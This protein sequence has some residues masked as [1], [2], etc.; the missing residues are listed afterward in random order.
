MAELGDVATYLVKHGVVG[1]KEIEVYVA[2]AEGPD[3]FWLQKK[4]DENII[5]EMQNELYDLFESNESVPDLKPL[6]GQQQLYAARYSDGNW[7]RA[8]L[9]AAIDEST[10][11]V[12]FVDYG[13]SHRIS[14]LDLRPLPSKWQTIPPIAFCCRLQVPDG[15][16]QW[17]PAIVGFFKKN[18]KSDIV[19]QVTFGAQEGDALIVESLVSP[20]GDIVEDLVKMMAVQLTAATLTHTESVIQPVESVGSPKGDVEEL[21]KASAVQLNAVATVPKI[22]PHQQS[23]VELL[24]PTIDTDT[25]D[26]PD[27]VEE[28]K[29][30]AKSLL[31][32]NRALLKRHNMNQSLITEL[33][34]LNLKLMRDIQEINARD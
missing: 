25:E 2:F 4:S 17:S 21:S 13:D 3:Q 22:E 18:C 20:T 15:P 1:R 31:A 11:E 8:Q 19:F 34:S 16:D 24:P 30:L 23:T 14:L 26:L 28:L 33:S 10:F 29:S 5:Y 27:S 9:T 12:K 7:F 32:K 6:V